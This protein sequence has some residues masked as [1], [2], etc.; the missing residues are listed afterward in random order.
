M[1]S[2]PIEYPTGD[3]TTLKSACTGAPGI[4]KVAMYNTSE[5][6]NNEKSVTRYIYSC[7]QN[8]IALDIKMGE[9][10]D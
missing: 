8:L 4:A 6:G 7:P 5:T 3:D 1:F 2:D 9:G 10:G